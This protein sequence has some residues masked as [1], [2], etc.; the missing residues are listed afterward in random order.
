M[1]GR[2]RP[3][4]SRTGTWSGNG[5]V[6]ALEADRRQVVAEPIPKIPDSSW[7]LPSWGVRPREGDFLC[8]PATLRKH[9]ESTREGQWPPVRLTLLDPSLYSRATQSPRQDSSGQRPKAGPPLPLYRGPGLVEPRRWSESPLLA[10]SWV[11]VW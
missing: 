11:P 7:N 5:A 9:V 6:A 1:L 2:R 8:S 4:S 3:L 10:W